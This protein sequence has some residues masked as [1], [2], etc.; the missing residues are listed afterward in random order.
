MSF[1]LLAAASLASTSG[2]VDPTSPTVFVSAAARAALTEGPD[3]D[4]T[5]VNLPAR[6]RTYRTACMTGAEWQ[7]AQK[8]AAYD[9]RTIKTPEMMQGITQQ[10]G[11]LQTSPYQAGNPPR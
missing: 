9:R 10:P 4:L 8:L 7:K 5:C 1:V 2:A 6:S 11:P 3:T